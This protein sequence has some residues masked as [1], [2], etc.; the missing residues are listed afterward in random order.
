MKEFMK[1]HKALFISIGFFLLFVL[2]TVLVKFVDVQAIG[3]NESSVGF[4][5]MNKWF[6]NLTGVTFAL[7]TVTDIASIVTVPIGCIFLVV[8]IVEWI[9]RKNMFKVDS[10]ILALGLFYIL[11]LATYLVFE[12]LKINY[13][14]VLIEG[15]LEPSFPSSTTVLSLT[16]FISAIDQAL[17]YVKNR[18][19]KL[20]LIIVAVVV[21]V[22][23]VIGRVISG[24]HWF[25][26]IIGAL[27]ISTAL[28]FAYYELKKAM[29]KVNKIQEEK[30]VKN[31]ERV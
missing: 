22:F 17:I 25:S 24:V 9:K 18:K 6:H 29:L 31:S 7:Y 21:S 19:L 28:L 15:K 23:L 2:F 30:E 27:L 3:P 20:S 12:F 10:N 26:D 14:P 5:S 8:G 4:A 11:V 1:N 13:R 16:F